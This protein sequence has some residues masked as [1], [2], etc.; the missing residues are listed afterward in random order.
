MQSMENYISWEDSK[1][2]EWIY[3]TAKLGKG[4]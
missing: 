3:E 4:D 1:P 2:N